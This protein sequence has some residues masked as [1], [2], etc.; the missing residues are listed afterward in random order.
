MN[1]GI[2]FNAES[3]GFYAYGLWTTLWLLAVS[4]AVGLV[5]SIACAVGRSA[6][7][8]WLNRLIW[9]YTYTFRG[10]P[11]LLQLYLIYYG[12][13]QFVWVR[14][15]VAWVAL[16]NAAFCAALCSILNTCA[17]TTEMIHGAIRATPAGEIEA[18]RAIGMSRFKLYSRIILPSALRRVIPAYSNEVIMTLQATSLASTVTLM[19]ITSVADRL[20]FRFYTPFEPF[21]FAGL[22]YLLLTFG[23]TRLFRLAERKWLA[24]LDR[25][26]T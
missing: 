13:A 5:A 8:W 25:A 11:M 3:L 15:S 2:V 18:G 24:H 7:P 16:S 20:Y 14:E 10:T 21:L 1:F 19:D 4:V 12:L 26:H 23:L 17:Y 6:G 9:L 22:I